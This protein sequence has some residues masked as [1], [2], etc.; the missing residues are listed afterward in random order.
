[1]DKIKVLLIIYFDSV[2]RQQ[3]LHWADFF[4]PLIFH[5]ECSNIISLQEFVK[6]FTD[7]ELN[8]LREDIFFAARQKAFYL[9]IFSG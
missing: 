8:Y 4:F 3:L 5:F 2:G 7:I 1:M 6:N 9:F